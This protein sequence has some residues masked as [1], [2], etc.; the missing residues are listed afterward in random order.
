MV[1]A[2]GSGGG[3]GEGG[4]TMSIMASDEATKVTPSTHQGSREELR[5]K[6]YLGGGGAGGGGGGDEGFG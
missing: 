1:V 5:L 6:M 3:A 4:G 2:E